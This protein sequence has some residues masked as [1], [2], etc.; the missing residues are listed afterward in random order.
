MNKEKVVAS[1]VLSILFLCI[2]LTEAAASQYRIINLTMNE[3]KEEKEIQEQLELMGYYDS[4]EPDYFSSA[5]NKALMQFQ[6]DYNLPETG[7]PG[8]LTQAAM[9][10]VD[11]MARIVHG[12]A[13]GESYLGQVAVAAVVL[14]RVDSP[15]FPASIEK[16]I[17]QQNAFTAV[18]DDQYLLTPNKRAYRAVLQAT[19]GLDPTGGAVYYYNPAGVT[20]T[21]IY[22]R[23]VITQIGKHHFAE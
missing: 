12:E 1:T 18:N 21:W 11:M 22:S 13:R 5:I 6:K 17:F 14:N 2:P 7:M 4:E 8:P 16:V 9:R 20:D 10:N 19:R 3:N 15:D 23:S